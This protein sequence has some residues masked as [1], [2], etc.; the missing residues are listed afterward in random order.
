MDN[1]LWHIYG[2]SA[3]YEHALINCIHTQCKKKFQRSH[4]GEY[5]KI[6]FEYR[7]VKCDFCGKDVT[8]ASMK[9]SKK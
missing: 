5:L 7:N 8:V 4:Q 3:V 2:H 9:V 1:F 6:E